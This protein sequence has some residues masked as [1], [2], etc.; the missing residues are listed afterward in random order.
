MSEAAAIAPT[1]IDPDGI[2]DVVGAGQAVGVSEKFIRREITAERLVARR[3]G[4]KIL[5]IKGKD[6][7]A[8]FDAHLTPTGNTAS[9]S[10]ETA[11]ERSG[12]K[13]ISQSA[14]ASVTRI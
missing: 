12:P 10:P 5:R 7:Q 9:S 2:Y 8:W 3:L 14:L 13:A 1:K 4:V 11:G 6:L